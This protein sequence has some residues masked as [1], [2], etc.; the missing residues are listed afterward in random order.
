[1][2]DWLTSIY[3]DHAFCERNLMSDGKFKATASIDRTTDESVHSL[4]LKI[5]LT[6]REAVELFDSPWCDKLRALTDEHGGVSIN[7]KELRVGFDPESRA[8]LSEVQKRL[9]EKF[10][11]KSPK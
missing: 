10:E 5:D 8:H 7:P 2:R 4:V 11:F 9:H 1:M 6:E 3:N